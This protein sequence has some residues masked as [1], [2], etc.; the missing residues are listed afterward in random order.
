MAPSGR[1]SPAGRKAVRWRCRLSGASKVAPRFPS[2]NSG[3]DVTPSPPGQTAADM[4]DG[5]HARLVSDPTAWKRWGPYVSERAW[6]TVREDYSA[7]GDA[8]DFFPHDHARSRAYR[9]SEDGLAAV[10]D[11]SQ[12]L[13]LG[14]RPLERPRPDPQGADLRPDRPEGN[15]GED[16]KEYWWYLDSHA[17]PL[18][19]AVA[20]PLPAGASSPTTSWCR[21]P[22]AGPARARVRAARHRRLRRRPLLGRRRRPTPRPPPTTC[23]IVV[24]VRNAG[25]DEATLARAA[26]AVVPQHLVVGQ[27]RPSRSRSSPPRTTPADRRPPRRSGRDDRWRRR[28]RHRAPTCCSARTRPTPPALGRRPGRPRSP[29]TA[30]TTTSSTAPPRSTPTASAPRPRLVPARR[31]TAGATVELRLRLASRR[32]AGPTSAT[33]STACS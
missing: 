14:L 20:L 31:S 5:E 30:S 24:G 25:P 32:S 29:R 23:C 11:G 1:R 33:S 26:D 8:W 3:A 13:C 19:D 4:S 17:H 21:E 7:D 6:G 12:R 2:G 27:R 15:H 16:A 22:P 10:C 9:W 18:V 28:R